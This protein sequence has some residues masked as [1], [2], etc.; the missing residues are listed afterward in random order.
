MTNQ[1]IPNNTYVLA[2]GTNSN[3]AFIV[4]FEARDPTVYDILYPVQKQ[5][6]NTVS[7]D[8]WFLKGFTSTSGQVLADWIKIAGT[9]M[10]Q[11]LIPNTGGDVFPTGNEISLLGDTTSIL[12]TGTPAT[13]TITIS[14]GPEVALTY[15]ANSG[16]AISSANNLNVLGTQGVLTTGSGSTLTVVGTPTVAAASSSKANLG[17]ASFNDTEFSVDSNGFVSLTAG[18]SINSIGVDAHTPPG[19]NPVLPTSGGLVTITGGQVAA[20]TTANVIRT[21]SLAANTFTI[22]VQRSQAVASSTLADNGVSHFNDNQFAVDANGF[23]SLASGF[24]TTGNF[25]PTI[26]FGGSSTGITYSSQNAIY[27]VFGNIVF[28]AIGI[29]LTSKGSASGAATIQTLPSAAGASLTTGSN[30][31]CNMSVTSFPANT[32]QI[33]GEVLPTETTM[34]LYYSVNAGSAQMTDANFA[35][36]TSIVVQGFYFT[37]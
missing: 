4:Q 8:F 9:N 12:T 20:G 32:F 24:Y 26:A 30:L 13:S 15:T 1:P 37:N 29:V 6:L 34:G 2:N 11:S 18:N 19:T 25:T 21:D 23:V 36:N 22:Q 17:T 31:F 27:T 28:V 7:N 33:L 35:N 16:T 14:A 5:W 10:V 3:N